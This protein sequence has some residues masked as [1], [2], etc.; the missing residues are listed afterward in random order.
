VNEPGHDRCTQCGSQRISEV[1]YT[2]CVAKSIWNWPKPSTQVKLLDDLKIW[3]I[4][5]CDSCKRTGYVHFLVNRNKRTLSYLKWTSLLFAICCVVLAIDKVF[6][7]KGIFSGMMSKVM[8]AFISLIILF[9]IFAIP[10]SIIIYINNSKK[11]RKAK[12]SKEFNV[13]NTVDAFKGEAERIWEM[14]AQGNTEKVWG[15]FELPK[16]KLIEEYKNIPASTLK[17][18]KAFKGN[19]PQER[20]REVFYAAKTLQELKTILPDELKQL[21]QGTTLIPKNVIIG[22]EAKDKSNLINSNKAT[23]ICI[24]CKSEIPFD[25]YSCPQCGNLQV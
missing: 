2:A 8:G 14:L 12:N 24:D 23:K 5:L 6:P 21:I 4:T 20:L 9:G 18:I 10:I 13:K 15:E 17:S 3:K 25:A 1:Y 16:Y 19:N 7:A 11:L 22:Q